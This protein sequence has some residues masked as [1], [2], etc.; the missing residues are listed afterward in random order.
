[1]S[2]WILAGLLVIPLAHVGLS[3]RTWPLELAAPWT[4]MVYLL[5]APHL[6]STEDLILLV[7][8][9]LLLDAELPRWQRAAVVLGCVG[10]Q[11]VG[12][13]ALQLASGFGVAGSVAGAAPVVAWLLK[14]GPAGVTVGRTWRWLRAT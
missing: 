10:P 11:F 7:P 6:S 9:G 12:G 13:S 1:V 14:L 2:G 5:F 4:M 3:R 8:L